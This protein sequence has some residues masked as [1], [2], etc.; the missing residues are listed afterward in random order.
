MDIEQLVLFFRWMLTINLGIFFF[1]V[2]LSLV[3]KNFM[4]SIQE[5]IF[6]VE[7]K[8]LKLSLYDFLGLYK[9][10]IIVFNLAPYIALMLVR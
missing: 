3:M 9:I 2:V 4:I 7:A 10:L 1:S 5:K 8:S 6:D